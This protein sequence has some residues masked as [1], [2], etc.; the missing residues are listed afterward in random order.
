MSIGDDDDDQEDQPDGG[1][2]E[3]EE[4]SPQ[5]SDDEPQEQVDDGA[6]DDEPQEQVDDGDGAQDDEPQEQVDDGSGAQDDEPAQSADDA[7]EEPPSDE[8]SGEPGVA[9]DE[10]DAGADASESEPSIYGSPDDHPNAVAED[11]E[12]DAGDWSAEDYQETAQNLFGEHEFFGDSAHQ[13]RLDDGW[14]PLENHDEWIGSVAQVR[15]EAA[16]SLSFYH[17]DGQVSALGFITTVALTALQEAYPD[18]DLGRL[19]VTQE[20]DPDRPRRD[21]V[22]LPSELAGLDPADKVDL[23]VH[24]T[25][26]GD[27]G[28]TSRCAAFAWTHALEMVGAIVGRPTP[29]LSPSYTMLQFQKRQGDARDYKWAWAGGDGTGSEA[30]PGPTLAAGGTCAQELWPDDQKHP[31][32]DDGAMAR[33]ALAHRLPADVS[34]VHIDDVKKVLTAGCPVVLGMNTGPAFSELGRDGVVNAAESP[35]GRHGRH[36]MLIVGYVGN[37]FIVKNSWGADWGDGGYCY[38]PKKVLQD[39][40]PEF[41]AVLAK[42]DGS[43]GAGRPPS[44]S[45][46]APAMQPRGAAQWQQPAPVA[47]AAADN[48]WRSIPQQSNPWRAEPAAPPVAVPAAAPVAVPPSAAPPAGLVRCTSCSASVRPGRFCESC[49][50]PLAVAA[51]PPARR[52][53]GQCGATVNPADRFCFAC[54]ARNQ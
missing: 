2:P 8:E 49:G 25:P 19:H 13:R 15:P 51:A 45:P 5:Q 47:P 38:V 22:A 12:D 32:A 33:D 40:D 34:I 28:Q 20:V 48:P 1:E 7:Q 37:Y 9:T 26:V 42:R 24:C 10:P 27:Q 43:L 30:E 35:S 54:G 4:E 46:S 14:S 6:Q 52:F 39:A 31:R 53:C 18:L 29:R 3:P 50:K 23:R 41:E 16:E 21:P 11:F 44:A 36:A 17:R